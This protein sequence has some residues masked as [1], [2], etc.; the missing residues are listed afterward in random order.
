MTDPGQTTQ[1]AQPAARS[2][3]KLYVGETEL[4]RAPF[5]QWGARKLIEQHR[6]ASTYNRRLSQLLSGYREKLVNGTIPWTVKPHVRGIKW[7][8]I[9]AALATLIGLGGAAF[10]MRRGNYDQG[11]V[12]AM[13]M[14]TGFATAKVTD[15]ISRLRDSP[16]LAATRFVAPKG[17][18]PEQRAEHGKLIDATVAN[19]AAANQSHRDHIVALEEYVQR[20]VAAGKLSKGAKA[21]AARVRAEARTHSREEAARRAAEARRARATEQMRKVVRRA[22]K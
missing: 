14:G 4:G 7:D 18:Y 19:L 13:L 22:G 17:L 3:R 2:L 16:E 15:I 21:E 9:N 8:R 10:L 6:D 5:T 20:R 1:A 11:A 12:A